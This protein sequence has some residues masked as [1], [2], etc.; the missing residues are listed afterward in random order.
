[1]NSHRQKR[2]LET[3]VEMW[4]GPTERGVRES[5]KRSETVYARAAPLLTLS[6]KIRRILK[7]TLCDMEEEMKKQ[8]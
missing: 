4:L 8:Y 6:L 7:D 5:T 3:Y 1:M 2:N